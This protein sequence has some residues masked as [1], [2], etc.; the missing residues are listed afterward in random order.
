MPLL[1]KTGQFLIAFKGVDAAVAK[2]ATSCLMVP[3]ILLP[4]L[5][6]SEFLLLLCRDNCSVYKHKD[7]VVVVVFDSEQ[8]FAPCFPVRVALVQQIRREMSP[9]DRPR[10]DATNKTGRR[11]GLM[12]TQD[13]SFDLHA[14][15]KH[16]RPIRKLQQRT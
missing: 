7:G 9:S 1:P 14:P 12:N 8:M 11:V 3:V 13:R 5:L 15:A 16:C 2:T 10:L 4:P 6:C